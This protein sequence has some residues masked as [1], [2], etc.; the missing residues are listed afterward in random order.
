VKEEDVAA[1]EDVLC[2]GRSDHRTSLSPCSCSAGGA[3]RVKSDQRGK[4]RILW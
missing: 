4:Y 1:Y 2:D 3:L